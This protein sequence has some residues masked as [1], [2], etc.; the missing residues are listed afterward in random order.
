MY[1]HPSTP[2]LPIDDQSTPRVSNHLSSVWHCQN[3]ST[4]PIPN[5]ATRFPPRFTSLLHHTSYPTISPLRL[6]L[7]AS[8]KTIVISGGGTGIGSSI[9]TSF[10]RAGASNIGI[11][12]RNETSLVTSAAAVRTV[13]LESTKVA[14]TVADQVDAVATNAAFETLAKELGPIDVFIANAAY[15]PT[16]APAATQDPAA[17]ADFWRAFEVNVKGLQHACSAFL[18]NAGERPMLINVSAGFVHLPTAA[19][20]P[21]LGAYVA[22]KAAADRYVQALAKERE[23]LH[24]V[25]VHPGRVQTE[26]AARR[27][28]K[29]PDDGEYADKM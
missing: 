1:F 13:A 29:A 26:M 4:T 16:P 18:A 25:S 3:K 9:A 7:S 10:A 24:V 14:Y 6:A 27:G 15:L 11:F 2:L 5:M 20:V 21:G 23:E 22:S 28:V 17:Q 8:G 19:Q 12:G